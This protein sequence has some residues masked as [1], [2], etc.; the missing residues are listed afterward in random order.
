MKKKHVVKCDNKN[1]YKNIV[2]M[3]LD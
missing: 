3:V 2:H 1:Q